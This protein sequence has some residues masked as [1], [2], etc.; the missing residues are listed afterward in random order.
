MKIKHKE[1]LVNYEPEHTDDEVQSIETY[2]NLDSNATK[3]QCRNQKL[4]L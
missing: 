3:D 4:F 1:E 2:N